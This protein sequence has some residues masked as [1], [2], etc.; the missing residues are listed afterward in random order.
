MQVVDKGARL[1]RDVTAGRMN[2]IDAEL[3]RGDPGQNDLQGARAHM[4]GDDEIGLIGDAATI[5]G[6]AD[7]RVAVVAT[8]GTGQRGRDRAAARLLEGPALAHGG[9]CVIETAMLV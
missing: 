8:D 5:A 3:A 7:E 4:L 2:R 9:L 6:H 1:Q